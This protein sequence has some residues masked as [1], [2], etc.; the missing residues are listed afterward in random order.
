MIGWVPGIALCAG[1][2]ATAIWLQDLEEHAF[3]H[4]YLEALVIAILLGLLSALCGSRAR[5]GAMASL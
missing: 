2:S 1:I 5:S 3:G 4:P